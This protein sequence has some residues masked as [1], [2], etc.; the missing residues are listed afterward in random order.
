MNND[1]VCVRVGH[2]CA[3]PLM[4]RFN[5]LSTIRVSLALYNTIDDIDLFINSLK[6]SLRILG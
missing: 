5:M 3:E 2:H 4:K 6:K 1:N